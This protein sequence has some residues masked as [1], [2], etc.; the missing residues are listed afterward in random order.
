MKDDRN[1]VSS[2]RRTVQYASSPVHTKE[3]TKER[4]HG[5]IG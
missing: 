4:D 1:Q 2:Y 5:R 3:K